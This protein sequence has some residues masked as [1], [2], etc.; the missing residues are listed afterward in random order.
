LLDLTKCK[1][2]AIDQLSTKK[3]LCYWPKASQNVMCLR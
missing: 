1:R 2:V 3:F